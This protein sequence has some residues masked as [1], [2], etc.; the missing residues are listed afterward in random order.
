MEL[1][2]FIVKV[3]IIDNLPNFNRMIFFLRDSYKTNINNDKSCEQ[4]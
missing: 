3:S 4:L 1:I 2:F